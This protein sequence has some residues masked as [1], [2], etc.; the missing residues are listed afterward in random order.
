MLHSSKLDAM[1]T[2]QGSF[3][4]NLAALAKAITKTEHTVMCHPLK[5][6]TNHGVVAF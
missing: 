1:E 6:N 3:A 4:R 5:T 2:G